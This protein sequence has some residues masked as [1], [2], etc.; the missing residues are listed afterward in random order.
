MEHTVL[1]FY[2]YIE[3]KNPEKLVKEQRALCEKLNL[4]GRI[5]IANEGINGTIEGEKD[6]IKE[7]INATSKDKRFRDIN[8][9]KSIGT[10]KA[11]RK[12]TVKTRAEIVTTGIKNKD[13]GPLKKVT[14]KKLSADELYRWYQEGREFYIIDMR[15]EYEHEVGRFKNSLWPQGLGHFRDVPNAIKNIENLKDKT[16]VT[17]CTGGVRCET[18]SGLLLKYGFSDVYQLENGIVTFMQKYPNTF[19]EGKLL[20]FDK[21]ETIGFNVDSPDYKMVGKCR[22]CKK[23]SENMVNY[24]K[25]GIDTYG[26]VCEECINERKVKLSREALDSWKNAVVEIG[27]QA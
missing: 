2:K 6:K 21:R 24:W 19:F 3:I 15:N 10:G 25:N 9:K 11:F 8:W 26:I 4:K 16:I 20:V 22:V 17:V 7:Y 5:L 1:L 23:P 18:A 13:F 14:G 12:L 27:N